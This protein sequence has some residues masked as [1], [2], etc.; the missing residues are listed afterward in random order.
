MSADFP[1]QVR[2]ALKQRL[3]EDVVSIFLPG[4]AGSAIPRCKP[5]PFL[6]EFVRTSCQFDALS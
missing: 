6:S 1:G 2:K 3:G 4:L 5:K